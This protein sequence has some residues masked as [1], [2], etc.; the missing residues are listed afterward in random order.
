MSAHRYR[1]ASVLE[2][3]ATGRVLN[4]VTGDTGRRFRWLWTAKREARR[5]NDLSRGP[6]PMHYVVLERGE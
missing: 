5:Y 1:V 3:D 2:H 6:L 4:Q